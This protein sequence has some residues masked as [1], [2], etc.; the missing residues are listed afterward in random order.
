MSKGFKLSNVSAEIIKKT[1]LSLDT[2]EATEMD[3][4]PA[5]FVRDG[6][7]KSALP[8]INIINLSIKLSTF[9]EES[10]ITK[11][12]PIFKKGARADPKNY[13]PI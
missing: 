6:D 11:S 12:K 2:N 1:L 7:E 8:L 10:K 5:R 4:I 3:Q 13:Q 9:L